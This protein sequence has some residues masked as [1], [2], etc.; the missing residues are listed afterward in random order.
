[1]DSQNWGGIIKSHRY[2]KRRGIRSSGLRIAFYTLMLF[3]VLA[4]LASG[5]YAYVNLKIKGS[6]PEIAELQE[7]QG[8]EP[9]NVL[10]L[11]SDSREGLS[12]E[13]LKKYDP[14]GKDR[15]TGRRADTIILARFDPDQEKAV[16]LYF[17][18]D[19]RVAYKSGKMGKVNAVYQKG[20]GAMVEQIQRMTGLP[21]HHYVEV[22]FSG[23]KGI[24][25]AIGGIKVFFEK[26][27]RE[28]DSGL[29]VPKGCV[30]L[31]GDQALAFV[32]V[33]KID[34]DFGRIARQQLFI[35]LMMEKVTNAGTY[36]NPVKI[37]KL[38]NLFQKNVKTDKELA[39]GEMKTL[40]FRLR[41]VTAGKVDMRVIP[42]EPRNIG[43]VS[44]V[45]ANDRQTEILFKAL[46]ERSPLPDYGRTGVSA[47]ENQD[48]RVSVLNGTTSAE[49][50]KVEADKLK[51]DGF[52]D[53]ATGNASPHAKTTVYF[54]EGNEE[55]AK[56][57]AARYSAVTKAM[58][59]TIQVES[60]LALVLGEDFIKAAPASSVKPSPAKTPATPPKNPLVT[61]LIH[62]CPK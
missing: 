48:V 41:G 51:A 47:I 58:P 18:R 61:D 34:S 29:N 7:K 14:S 40:A 62:A 32:R 24:V 35:K 21:I 9:M 11:G 15:N 17:P 49:L 16:L 38:V 4:L 22:N 5:I 3:L 30:E 37:V 10:I 53:P 54:K 42:S 55:K 20:P 33:R 45:V 26:P 60:E 56:I 12:K 23:F 1:L 28:K 31:K 25:D 19:L 6:N 39:V 52:P 50:A 36:L 2:R 27:F 44:Y 46:R 57:V 13:D 59:P 43:G 8:G